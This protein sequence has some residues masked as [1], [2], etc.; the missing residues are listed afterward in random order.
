MT[1]ATLAAPS[2]VHFIVKQLNP[3]K[4]G[5]SEADLAEAIQEVEIQTQ[6]AG[7]SFLKI[8]VIDA[9]PLWAITDSGLIA[10]NEDGLL[11]ELQVEFP[12]GS[13]YFWRLA[14]VEG[15]TEISQANLILTFEDLVVARL[16]EQWGH[17]TFP[18][19]STT[20]A[21][22]V[23]ALVAEANLKEHLNPPIRFVSPGQNR[24]EPVAEAKPTKTS[25]AKKNEETAANRERGIH[26]G[27]EFK[28]KG[29]SPSPIQRAL[30]NEVMGIA[31]ELNAGPLATEALIEACIDENDF[32]NNPGGGGGSTGLL[33]LIPS[34]AAALGVDPLN[35]KQCVTAFLTNTKY[36]DVPGGA[37]GYA[38]AHPNASAAEVATALQGNAAGA[39]VYA[40][41]HSEAQEIVHAAGGVRT[42]GTTPTTSKESDVGQLS[43]GTQQNPDEDSWDCITRLAQEVTWFAFTDGRNTL[44]YFD[45]PDFIAQKPSL[46]VDVVDNH[47]IKED[48]QGHPVSEYGAII[49]PLSFTYDNTA[50]L[51]R[52]THKVKGKIQ[53][54]SR[55]SKPQTPSEV[56][57]SMD[58]GITEFRAGDVFVFK[59]CGPI[60]ENGGRWIVSDATRECLKTPYTKFILVPPTEPLPEPKA[61]ATANPTSGAAV[62]PK[63][64]PNG[65]PAPMS[66]QYRNPPAQGPTGTGTFQ[67]VTVAKWTIPMLEYG[68]AHGWT[69]QITSGYR[70]GSAGEHSKTQYPGGAV[71][72]GGPG[73]VTNSAGQNRAA[74]FAACNGFTGLPLIPAQFPPYAEYPEGDAGHSSGTGH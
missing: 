64:V 24:K 50:F 16:R 66:S 19:G 29:A 30:A 60:S 41:F 72:F 32:T 31:N 45:G 4:H 10:V 51:Y 11:N 3:T 7:A 47:I 61:T 69:G 15:S 68:K 17:R 57:M 59:N 46:Y 25:T 38:K 33:Q 40:A 43:R 52:T 71:D 44:F 34:T 37:I 9:E 18:P 22:G 21:Q 65:F 67:G 14:A 8:H 27:A 6:I 13:K 39:S 23:K 74:F 2:I 20:R 62:T 49:R 70:P 1:T 58:C 53:R 5:I 28:I 26:A 63:E 35:V 48:K 12:E 42:G 56:R 73:P 54:K 55:I 36:H